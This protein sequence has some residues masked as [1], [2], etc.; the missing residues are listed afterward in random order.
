[1]IVL[2]IDPGT[3]KMGWGIV[4]KV[5][6]K[7][8]SAFGG[9]SSKSKVQSPGAQYVAHGLIK[10][11]SA[12]SRGRRLSCLRCEVERLLKEHEVAEVAVEKIFFNINK[13]TAISVSQ[14]L[15]IVHLAAADMGIP[16]FEYNALAVKRLLTGYGRADKKVVQ[17][18]I[19]K[20]LRLKKH[21][22]PVHAAD[23][24]AVALC[25]ILKNYE[26]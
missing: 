13:K 20:R 14:A 17:L 26:D 10:T 16:V 12:D 15:G 5:S 25:H 18:E 9:K 2:G 19:K 8:G 21:P 22:T 1:M 4:R 11:P 24:L 7:G 3:A 23:A 6:A